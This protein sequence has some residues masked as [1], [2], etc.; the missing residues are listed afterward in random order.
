MLAFFKGHIIEEPSM[1]FSYHTSKYSAILI[2]VVAI[3]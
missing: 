3:H 2:S 1:Y